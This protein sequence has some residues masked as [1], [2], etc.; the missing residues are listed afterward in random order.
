MG[1]EI[2]FSASTM[3]PLVGFLA[4]RW[5]NMVNVIIK[6]PVWETPAFTPGEEQTVPW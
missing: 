4:K 2:G 3:L 6:P 1:A 5:G